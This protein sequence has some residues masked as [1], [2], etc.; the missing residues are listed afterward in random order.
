MKSKTKQFTLTLTALLCGAFS[1]LAQD[2]S[3]SV[4]L[5]KEPEDTATLIVVILLLLIPL[6]LFVFIQVMAVRNFI[7]ARK[8]KVRLAL[9]KSRVFTPIRVPAMENLAA[10]ERVNALYVEFAE[11]WLGETKFDVFREEDR[12]APSMEATDAAFDTLAKMKAV[13][14]VES[15]I[16]SAEMLNVFGAFANRSQQRENLH[17]NNFRKSGAPLY[18]S[19]FTVIGASIFAL[20]LLALWIFIVVDTDMPLWGH[21][22]FAVLIIMSLMNAFVIFSHISVA[23]TVFLTPL[24]LVPQALGERWFSWSIKSVA[25]GDEIDRG[26]FDCLERAIARSV[27]YTVDKDGKTNGW[28]RKGDYDAA[29]A[30]AIYGNAARKGVKAQIIQIVYGFVLPWKTLSVYRRN[31]ES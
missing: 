12:V 24:R 30:M 21:L 23:K 18:Y 1:A 25:W 13:P 22:V 2:A 7:C 14:G 31:F 4:L 10:R 16:V 17:P 29:G 26:Y 6:A 20:L 8:A 3:K 15:D 9:E 28:I 27:F 19:W 5:G 11:K